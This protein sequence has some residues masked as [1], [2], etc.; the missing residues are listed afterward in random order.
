MGDG[1]HLAVRLAAALGCGL[2]AGVFFAFSSFVMTALAR[3]PP[4]EGI[5]AMQSINLVVRNPLFF[6]VF[7]GTA[8]ACLAIVLLATLDWQAPGAA[9]A[10]AAGMLYLLGT[11]GVTV[12]FNVPLNESLAPL[13][14]AA[15]ASAAFWGGYVDRWSAWNHVRTAAATAAAGLLVIAAYLAGRG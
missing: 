11:F 9:C 5:A 10:L 2:M 3:L 6:T 8:A 15:A 4:H 1:L 13:D 7:F 12:A 14:P